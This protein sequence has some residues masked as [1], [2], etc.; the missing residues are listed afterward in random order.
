[1][2]KL[3]ILASVLVLLLCG[4]GSG[5][6]EA[7]ITQVKEASFLFVEDTQEYVLLFALCDEN[8]EEVASSAKVSIEIEDERGNL[9]YKGK[10]KLREDD[11]GHFGGKK[12]KKHNRARVRI[13]PDEMKPGKST[14][15]TVYFSV[16]K[17]FKFSFEEE[18]CKAELCLPIQ[19]YYFEMQQTPQEIIIK[20]PFWHSE[21]KYRVDKLSWDAERYMGTVVNLTLHGQ[22]VQGPK[23]T[24]TDMIRYQ[25]VDSN[26]EVQQSGEIY[27]GR[28]S[29]GDKFTA[30]IFCND[31]IPGEDYLI[32]FSGNE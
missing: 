20:D 16:K 4:C 32:Q 11:V 21:A 18:Q 2:K 6:S 24:G 17:T 25:I 7:E 5:G 28:Y 8:G 1:M 26:G 14:S 22:K 27:M 23:G 10:K 3:I 31:L 30:S 29:D 15:G 12:Q 13:D 9:I 19:Q